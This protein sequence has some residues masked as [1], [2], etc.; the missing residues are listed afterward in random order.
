MDRN[1]IASFLI[2]QNIQCGY[3]FRIPKEHRERNESEIQFISHLFF[4]NKLETVMTVK[5]K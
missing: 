1:H 5:Q 3:G 2:L 4:S